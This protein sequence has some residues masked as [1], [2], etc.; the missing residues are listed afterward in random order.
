MESFIKFWLE[1]VLDDKEVE[2]I[3]NEALVSIDPE[4]LP[5]SFVVS[6]KAADIAWK[7]VTSR[8]NVL[9]STK[10][11][12]IDFVVEVAKQ[13]SLNLDTFKDIT[14]LADATS[15]HPRFARKV[16]ECIQS[17]DTS[18]LYTRNM[19]FNAIKATHWPEEISKFVLNDESNSR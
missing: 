8:Q 5:K 3:F 15:C 13:C 2:A 12:G 7:L 6:R 10:K 19:K 1:T 11:A 4:F 16:L 9:Q 17:G 14:I 18:S